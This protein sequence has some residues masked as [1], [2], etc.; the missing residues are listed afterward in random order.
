[1]FFFFSFRQQHVHKFFIFTTLWL[2]GT[3]CNRVSSYYELYICLF[4]FGL[5]G[6]T[7][8]AGS[9]QA[10]TT[11]SKVCHY[12]KVYV[13]V[14]SIYYFLVITAEIKIK[15]KKKQTKLK[16]A[17]HKKLFYRRFQLR[18]RRRSFTICSCSSSSRRNISVVIIFR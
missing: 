2:A 1:M 3:H 10:T 17:F 12:Y 5:C 4:V 9:K 13:S 18:R 11:F 15:I 6:N 8:S 7:S 14:W 16:S